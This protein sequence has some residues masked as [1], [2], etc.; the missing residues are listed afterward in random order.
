[1]LKINR[2]VPSSFILTCAPSASKIISP[3]A[4]IVTSVL[5]AMMVSTAIDPTFVM[6]LSLKVV[7]PR[8]IDPVAVRFDVPMST[9]PATLS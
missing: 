7:A 2:S 5:S 9:F 3:A 8:L 6:L 4:S 1:V